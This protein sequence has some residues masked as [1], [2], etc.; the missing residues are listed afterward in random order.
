MGS[1]MLTEAPICQTAGLQLAA[2]HNPLMSAVEL[3]QM[4]RMMDTQ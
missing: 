1:D 3:T 2:K 4:T